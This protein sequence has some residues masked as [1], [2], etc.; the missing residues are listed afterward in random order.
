MDQGKAAAY[1]L[2]ALQTR[3]KL[4]IKPGDEVYPGQVVGENPRNHSLPVNPTKEKQLDNMRASGSDK[5]IQLTPPVVFSLERAIEYIEQDELVEATP[6][7]LRLRKRILDANQ[8]RKD[9]KRRT[10]AAEA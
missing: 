9:E 1:A 8:R 6:N 4:F 2:D 5:A 7:H 3:G 10:A